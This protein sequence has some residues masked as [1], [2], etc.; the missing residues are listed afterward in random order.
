MSKR[1]EDKERGELA[2]APSALR[3]RGGIL[4]PKS[5]VWIHSVLFKT[6]H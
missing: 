1:E 2:V 6:F 4:L 3:T 5:P